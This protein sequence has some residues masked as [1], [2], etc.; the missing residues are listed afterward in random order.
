M[1]CKIEN[2][3]ERQFREVIYR[4]RMLIQ[5]KLFTAVTTE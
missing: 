1:K 2:E 4:L 5:L 3:S